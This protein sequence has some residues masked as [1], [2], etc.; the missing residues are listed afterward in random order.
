MDLEAIAAE[1]ER[2]FVEL[3]LR[4]TTGQGAAYRNDYVFVFRI[5]DGFIVEIHEHLDTH[6]AQ[7]LLFDPAGQDSPLDPGPLDPRPPEPESR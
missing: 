1:G 3:S 6:Y 4:A 2:V 5:R 7:R